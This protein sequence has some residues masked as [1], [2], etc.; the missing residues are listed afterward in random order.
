MCK[1]W[2]FL[3]LGMNHEKNINKMRILTFMSLGE[4]SKVI[5]FDLLQQQLQINSEEV[6]SFV[7]DGKVKKSFLFFKF[8]YY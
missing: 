3:F 1:I 4:N 7:I 8:I 5:T 2:L 6:E